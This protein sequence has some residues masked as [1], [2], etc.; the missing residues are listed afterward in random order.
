MATDFDV[1]QVAQFGNL[2]FRGNVGYGGRDPDGSIRVSFTPHQG[3]TDAPRSEVALLVRRSSIASPRLANSA[4]NTYGVSFGETTKLMD[5][6]DV[7]FGAKLENSSVVGRQVYIEPMVDAALT[8]G[9]DGR[10]YYRQGGTEGTDSTDGARLTYTAQG[11]AM[12]RGRHQETGY[13]R[14]W[15]RH[16]YSISYYRDAISNLALTGIGQMDYAGPDMTDEILAGSDLESFTANAGRMHAQGIQARWERQ[17]SNML[18]ASAHAEYGTALDSAAAAFADLA[19]VRCALRSQM[20]PAMGADVVLKVRSSELE[21][22]YNQTIGSALTPVAIAES[23]SAATAPYWNIRI[24]QPLP[25]FLPAHMDA[26][27]DIRNLL[28][29]GYRPVLGQDGRT[30]YLVQAPR[31]LRGGLAFTF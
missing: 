21:S 9:K 5:V 27:I 20:R 12:Q 2:N 24:R 16:H 17:F 30:L 8:L 14:R 25:S 7:R 22:S 11:V 15:N 4:I 19:A 18:T 6:V 29:Q 13:E 28:A 26:V 31:A 1:K 3:S 23:R 10:L